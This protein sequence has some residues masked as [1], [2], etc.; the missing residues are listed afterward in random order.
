MKP[1]I[2]ELK[3]EKEMFEEA[4]LKGKTFSD[5]LEELDPSEE[6]SG[7]LA[8]LSP[9]ERRLAYHGV[10]VAP[11][12]AD[13][14]Q[15][16]FA[17]T[18]SSVL[19]PEYVASQVQAGMLATSILP[20]LVATTTN[21]DSHTYKKLKLAE[22]LA[23]RQLQEVAEGAELPTTTLQTAEHA[24]ELRKFGR[25]LKASY[26]ALRLQR[27]N[28]VSV[29]LQR[30]GAQLAID[31]S[32]WA[33]SVILNGDGNAN[34]LLDTDSEVSGTLDYDELIRLYL[35]FADGYKLTTI[36][37]GDSLIRTILNMNEFKDPEAGF[38]FQKTG[39]FVS[40]VGAKLV[41][42]TSAS[43]LPSD[44]VLGLDKR[45]ALEQITEH[46]VITEVDRL[47]DRQLEQ[48]SVSK[49]TGFAK[50]HDA[51]FQ[52]IDVTHN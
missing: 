11:P 12:N 43:V 3:L 15:K 44:L 31:E 22:S 23:E 37:V 24:V 4:R 41:R 8:K 47:I 34:P 38:G 48:T 5:L 19:F 21:I 28:V 29:F 14:L 6:Y 52:A 51:A 7:E 30:I 40:P 36:V 26:E 42:W 33:L 27:I 46:G 2:K 35:E 1:S 9:F 18:A 50:L 25:L 13:I 20:E 39:E 49:W 45:F 10:K 17:S 32:D 16:F